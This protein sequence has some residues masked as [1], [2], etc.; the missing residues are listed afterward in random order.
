MAGRSIAEH[1][2]LQQ[3]ITSQNAVFLVKRASFSI[4][5][6]DGGLR[7]CNYSERHSTGE[8]R[9]PVKK[10]LLFQFPSRAAGLNE[11]RPGG[12]DEGKSHKNP[13]CPLC[14]LNSNRL[15]TSK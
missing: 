2:K 4:N 9:P 1:L 12:G 8:L 11:Q 15:L 7:N 10:S 14:L 3:E 6:E 13:R 5:R